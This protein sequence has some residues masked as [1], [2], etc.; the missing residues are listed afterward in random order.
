[1]T[2]FGDGRTALK[3]SFG[4]YMAPLGIDIANANNPI[5]TS[6]NSIRRTWSDTNANFVPDCNLGNFGENGECGAINNAN[7]GKNNPNATRYDDALI[8]GFGK[9]DYFWDFST[10]LQH[11][12]ATGVSVSAGYYRNWTSIYSIL[13]GVRWGAGVTDN[14]AVTP[15]DFDPFCITAPNDPRLPGGGG[16]DVCG[17]TTSARRSSDSVKT[18]SDKHPTSANRRGS[19]TSSASGSTHGSTTGQYSAAAW[20]RGARWRTT[21]SW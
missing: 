1:M 15:A 3:T 10:E 8:R 14:L 11:E 17:S 7:F 21:A 18:S 5:N 16:Y 6:I 9:R 20:T 19:R 13:G 2:L 12:L 4:R